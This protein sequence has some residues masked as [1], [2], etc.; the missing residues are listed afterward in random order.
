MNFGSPLVCGLLQVNIGNLFDIL[1]VAWQYY[2]KLI[3]ICVSID[4]WML[5]SLLSSS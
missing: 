3:Y 1:F 5:A 4:F 2:D